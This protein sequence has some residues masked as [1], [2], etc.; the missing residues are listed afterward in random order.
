MTS[1]PAL[2][3]NAPQPV[4]HTAPS[5]RTGDACVAPLSAPHRPLRPQRLAIAAPPAPPSSRT[6]CPSDARRRAAKIRIEPELRVDHRRVVVE[7][8][9]AVRGGVLAHPGVE[10]HDLRPR[11]EPGLPRDSRTPAAPTRAPPGSRSPAPSPPSPSGCRR[12]SPASTG[13]V[14]PAM[15]L[16][17][18]RITTTAGLSATTSCRKRI[19]ICGVVCPLMPRPTYGLPGNMRREVRAPTRR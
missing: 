7:I 8:G 13:P 11:L 15:S 17:P 6:P 5:I 19:S 12:S 18:A 3:E 1:C 2:R 10:R 14:L 9:R 4:I 16:V